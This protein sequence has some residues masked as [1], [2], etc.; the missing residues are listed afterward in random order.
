MRR[1]NPDDPRGNRNK[2][3]SEVTFNPE[4]QCIQKMLQSLLNTNWG[5]VYLAYLV[6][7]GHFG[8]YPAFSMVRRR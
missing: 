8:N 1:R 2:N 5:T 4:L 3:K 6:L 7:D